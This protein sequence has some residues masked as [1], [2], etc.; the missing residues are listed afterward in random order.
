MWRSLYGAGSGLFIALCVAIQ[1]WLLVRGEAPAAIIPSSIR[2]LSFFT[3]LTNVLAA[4]ALVIPVVAPRSRA[5]RFLARPS[6]RTAI[7][8]YIIMVGVVYYLLLTNISGRHGW[9]LTLERTLHY[10]TPP[11]FVLDWILFVDKR[12]LTWRVG[13]S[14]LAF[15]L[16][17][18]GW[19]L[20][21]GAVS[22]WY[23]YP[24][25]DAAEL[26]YG[27]VIVNSIGLIA[28]FLALEAA[29]VA[30]GRL[31]ERVGTSTTPAR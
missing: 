18:L 14:G 4:A 11:L 10:L 16:I 23:P 24:F 26:G 1:Y 29:L 13:A 12:A 19:L 9:E 17:Y 30:A 25:I 8:G 22:G 21:Y 20:A 28:C 5:G 7:A 2:F 3:I 15:P 6:V 31:I 27:R